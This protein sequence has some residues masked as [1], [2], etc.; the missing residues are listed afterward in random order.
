M[1]QETRFR[2]VLA[3]VADELSSASVKLHEVHGLFNELA[4]SAASIEKMHE[5]ATTLIA[6]ILII[7]W[8]CSRQPNT[9]R[10]INELGL[11]TLYLKWTGDLLKGQLEGPERTKPKA[12]QLELAFPAPPPNTIAA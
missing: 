6:R 5:V 4:Q 2:Q 10:V 3:S 7:S 12:V 9:K 1:N 11:E 8:E